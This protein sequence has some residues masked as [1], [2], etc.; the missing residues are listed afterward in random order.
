MARP[1]TPSSQLAGTSFT[2]AISQQ[3]NQNLFSLN[4]RVG[5]DIVLELTAQIGNP[6]SEANPCY[7]GSMDKWLLQPACVRLHSSDHR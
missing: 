2:Y 1:L 7:L 5:R 6:R 3:Q 4:L